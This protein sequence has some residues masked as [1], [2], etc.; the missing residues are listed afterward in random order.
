[1]NGLEIAAIITA[2]GGAIA[3]IG[4]LVSNTRK[5]EELQ[6]K[7]DHE[8][9]YAEKRS[10]RNRRD[11]ILLGENLRTARSDAAKLAIIVDESI[12]YYKAATGKDLPIDPLLIKHMREI[13]Y[14]TGELGPIDLEAVKAQQ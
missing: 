11:L 8:L 13:Y 1:M 4:S 7:L 9:D 6:Q 3:A 5:I 10:A 14:A 12:R 2:I